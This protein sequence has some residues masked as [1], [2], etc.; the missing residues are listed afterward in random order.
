MAG[1]LPESDILDMRAV[2]NESL[3][4]TALILRYTSHSDGQGGET[5][6]WAYAGT[7]PASIAPVLTGTETGGEAPR[8][9]H[10]WIATMPSGIDV[11]ETDRLRIG[12]TEYEVVAV[13]SPRTDQ[14]STRVECVKMGTA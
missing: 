10:P 11:K 7:V 6:S 8:A 13:R 9:F 14:L 2:V 4:G 3:S 1:L 5:Q 12:D